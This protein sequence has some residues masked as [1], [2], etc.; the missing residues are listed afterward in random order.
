MFCYFLT[1]N[2]SLTNPDLHI[3]NI[4][5]SNYTFAHGLLNDKINGRIICEDRPSYNHLASDSFFDIFANNHEVYL[6]IYKCGLYVEKLYHKRIYK[7]S[8]NNRKKNSFEDNFKNFEICLHQDLYELKMEKKQKKEL[9]RIFKLFN[10]V[11][12]CM[13]DQNLLVR[14]NEFLCP[15]NELINMLQNIN[16]N[17]DKNENN[18]KQILKEVKK[19]IKK[20]CKNIKKPYD[21]LKIL[22]QEIANVSMV[23]E[24][25]TRKTIVDKT[26]NTACCTGSVV[27]YMHELES[28]N[29]ID[30]KTIDN[31]TADASFGLKNKIK[32]VGTS[33][34]CKNKI[35]GYFYAALLLSTYFLRS[36]M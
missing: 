14:I 6:Y 22:Q 33:V 16:Y 20:K 2:T 27:K 13:D 29:I 25:L 3:Q 23:F 12:Y 9:R 5:N 34:G 35:F 26:A 11:S 17:L 10:L 28:E 8:T 32:E 7:K 21:I 1:I 19:A 15:E 24:K 36:F 18:E 4:P 30:E 31:G